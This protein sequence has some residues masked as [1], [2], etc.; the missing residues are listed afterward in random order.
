MKILEVK[1]L[2]EEL[3]EKLKTRVC[4]YKEKYQSSPRLA[5]ILVG[6]NSASESY[7]RT[8]S[9]MCQKLG[10]EAVDYRFSEVCK[11]SEV[12]SLISKL[13]NDNNVN[14]ILVQLPLPST[15][16]TDKVIN[17][18]SPEKDADG[19]T[20]YNLG[21]VLSD[22]TKI[23]AC[24]PKGIIRI[25]E[26]YSIP[27]ESKNI[28]IINRSVIV[29]RPLGAQLISTSLNA[30][31]FSC[32]SKT[33]ALKEILSISDIIITAV[34]KPNFI[35][36]S[37]NLKDNATIIDVSINRVEDKTKEKGYYVTGDVKTDD[38]TL[39]NLS[40][41]PVPGGVGLM[42]VLMLMENTIE[43]AEN[44]HR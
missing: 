2:K 43:L 26:Y 30:T 24:T 10:I 21:L 41:T 5:I 18:I 39:T 31:V 12:I 38:F 20:T 4:S 7:V 19:I 44:K 40:I 29:G 8:K 16:N 22:K 33:K 32:N 14:G 1:P 42:T 9:K 3:E 34:G 11:E 36:K 28:A 17:S 37:F 13:N 6:N 25:L 35:N 27:L 23:L 15:F